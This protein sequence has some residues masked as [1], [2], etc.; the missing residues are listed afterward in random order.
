[1]YSAA[2]PPNSGTKR[3]DCGGGGGIADCCAD[4]SD[5][6]TAL[7]DACGNDAREGKLLDRQTRSDSQSAVEHF[8]RKERNLLV[9]AVLLILCMNIS[10]GRYVLYP[11]MIFSTWVHE[12][13][14]GTC[15][16]V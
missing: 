15:A 11:F 13:C 10:T 3:N 14:H 8:L 7:P 1:M 6:A 2:P 5:A 12:M 16:C 4:G 9:A